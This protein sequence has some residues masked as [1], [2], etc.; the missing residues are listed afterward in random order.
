METSEIIAHI[1]TEIIRLKTARTILAGVTGTEKLTAVV[2]SSESSV[3]TASKPVKGK[4]SA[5]GKAKI[6]KAQKARWAKVRKAA[7]KAGAKTASAAL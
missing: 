6:A 3:K 7:K 5:E 4:M 2:S 1:D